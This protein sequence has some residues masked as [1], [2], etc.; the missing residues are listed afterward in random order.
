MFSFKFAQLREKYVDNTLNYAQ[1][2]VN[3]VK[4][5][6]CK[7]K[8]NTKTNTKNYVPLREKY[9]KSTQETRVNTEKNAK[10]W[11]ICEKYPKSLK[12]NLN[13]ETCQK[14]VEAGKYV[15]N[16]WGPEKIRVFHGHRISTYFLNIPGSRF[17]ASASDGTIPSII[18]THPYAWEGLDHD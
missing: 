5:K 17:S 11:T 13:Y 14:Y 1:K 16:T 18:H 12:V 9:A 8:T 10:N 15:E 4:W 2:V 7:I 6:Y 3:T